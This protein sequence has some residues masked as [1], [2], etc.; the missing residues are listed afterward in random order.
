MPSIDGCSQVMG[1]FRAGAA[2]VLA[3]G[4]SLLGPS[5]AKLERAAWSHSKISSVAARIILR[6]AFFCYALAKSS[7]AA[8]MTA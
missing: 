6:A 8:E 3:L 2:E 1:C 5:K 4:W 7:K